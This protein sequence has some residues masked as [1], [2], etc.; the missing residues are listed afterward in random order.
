MDTQEKIE[1]IAAKEAEYNK[2]ISE[3]PEPRDEDTIIGLDMIAYAINQMKQ[4]LYGIYD[5]APY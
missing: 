5:S 2:L 1:W 4:E 3:N